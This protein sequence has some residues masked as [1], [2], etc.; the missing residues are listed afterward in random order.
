MASTNQT[1]SWKA[2]IATQ[3]LEALAKRIRD[4]TELQVNDGKTPSL[5]VYHMPKPNTPEALPLAIATHSVP[6]KISAEK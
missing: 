1:C 6:S 3:P 4:G 5:T 2:F